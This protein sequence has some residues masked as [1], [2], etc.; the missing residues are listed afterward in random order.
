MAAQLNLLVLRCRDLAACKTFYEHLG[1][2][3]QR[4]QH[5]TGPIH[6][7]AQLEGLVFELYPLSE[8]AELELTRLGFRLSVEGDL[9]EILDRAGIAVLNVL[10][11]AEYPVYV[12]QDP[13]GR[14]V[15]L[16]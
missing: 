1:F 6:Y 10:P 9:R 2:S 12:V 3:F 11:H 15:V 7:A 13:E 8:G 4:E 5:G 16:S 14:K